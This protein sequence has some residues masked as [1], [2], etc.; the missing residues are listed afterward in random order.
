MASAKAADNMDSYVLHSDYS[1]AYYSDDEY[2]LDPGV[3]YT[4]TICSHPRISNRSLCASGAVHPG[5][6]PQPRKFQ[7]T[8][9]SGKS[10]VKQDPQNQSYPKPRKARKRH[11]KSVPNRAHLHHLRR[12]HRRKLSVPSPQRPIHLPSIHPTPSPWRAST[13]GMQN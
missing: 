11:K 12:D 5:I 6:S 7:P 9:S 2:S 4:D 1:D 3:D 8:S 13:A 10:L